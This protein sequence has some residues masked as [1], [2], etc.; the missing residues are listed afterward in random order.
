M[1][2]LRDILSRLRKSGLTV[3]SKKCC[4]G[5]QECRYLGHIIG[6]GKVK[7]DPLKIQSVKDFPI[8]H[9]KK[10]LRTFLGLTGYYRRFIPHYSS[11]AAP[12]TDLTR[13]S[14]SNTV[15]WN[16]SADNAFI[17]LK[18]AL[19][20]SPV[21]RGPNFDRPFILQSDA[22]DKGVGAVLSQIDDTGDDHAVAF[23][24]RKL[25]SREQKYS[26]IEKECLAIKDGISAFRVYLLGKR[27]TIQTD[28]R[29]LVWLDNL[30]D[31]NS[32]LTRWSLFLQQYD[33]ELIHCEGLANGNADSL[34]RIASNLV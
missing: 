7:P 25:L 28:H 9:T 2:H 15:T 29:A 31:K 14:A 8:P 3:K 32:R 34:S 30:K 23:Y 5:A 12:L 33:F 18:E 21:L 22:S 11:I 10:H 17:Q 4:F 24:S 1:H 20:S 19:C 26:T 6:G 13:K 27:F 16:K